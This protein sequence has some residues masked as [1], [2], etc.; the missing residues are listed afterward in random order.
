MKRALIFWQV[1]AIFASLG[2][3][4]EVFFSPDGGIR[5]Q[6]IKR[7]NLSKAT[8][9]IAVYSFTSGDIADALANAHQRGIKIRV[10][11]DRSQSSDRNDENNFLE[12]SGI[13]VRIRT[14]KGRGIMHDKF[15]VFDN[16]EA[17]TGSYN[18]T[19]NA[20][21]NNYENALFTDDKDAVGAYEAEFEKLW[22]APPPRTAQRHRKKR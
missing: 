6:I 11:R 9:D 10:I 16:K 15:A 20:E 19:G 2:F 12:Q 14:G 13:E 8:I 17:F 1:L 7:I 5:D 18:W 22:A 4:S 3:A 21:K